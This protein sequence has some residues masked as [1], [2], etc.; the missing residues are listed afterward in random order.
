MEDGKF[1]NAWG[2][3]ILRTKTIE[4]TTNKSVKITTARRIALRDLNC[5][6]GCNIQSYSARK[7]SGNSASE[8]WRNFAA[9]SWPDASKDGDTPTPVSVSDDTCIARF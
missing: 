8:N 4:A 1:N 2:L 6:A 7:P 5:E 3:D 9:R